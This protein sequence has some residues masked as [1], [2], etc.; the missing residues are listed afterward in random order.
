MDNI[1][2]IKI[3]KKKKEYFLCDIIIVQYYHNF[4]NYKLSLLFC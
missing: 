2:W 3:K 1:I 4:T